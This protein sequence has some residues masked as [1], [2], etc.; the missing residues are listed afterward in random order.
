M[1]HDAHNRVISARPA[2]ESQHA[3]RRCPNPPA[4]PTP[5]GGNWSGVCACLSAANKRHRCIDACQLGSALQSAECRELLLGCSLAAPVGSAAACHNASLPSA[6]KTARRINCNC[7]SSTSGWRATAGAQG[8]GQATV[9]SRQSSGGSNTHCQV[10]LATPLLPALSCVALHRPA[11][12]RQSIILMATDC[13]LQLHLSSSNI[14]SDN[15]NKNCGSRFNCNL[16]STAATVAAAS[17]VNQQLIQQ[18]YSF[19]HPKWHE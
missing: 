1:P 18:R 10:T 2:T 9:D 19:A 4:P 3:P 12:G 11:G 7:Q 14:S 6:A 13:Q 5:P 8:Q 15:N 16:L 17:T